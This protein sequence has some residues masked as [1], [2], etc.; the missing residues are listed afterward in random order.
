MASARCLVKAGGVFQADGKP[1]RRMGQAARGSPFRRRAALRPSG[2]DR[3]TGWP[4]GIDPFAD[5]KTTVGLARFQVFPFDELALEKTSVIT[6][7]P[8]EAASQTQ[9]AFPGPG[10]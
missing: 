8:R 5:V 1:Q 3:G 2:I 9:A 4:A 10:A 6:S 7:R